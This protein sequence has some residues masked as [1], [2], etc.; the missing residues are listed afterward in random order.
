MKKFIRLVAILGFSLCSFAAS[1]EESI[2][3]ELKFTNKSEDR[4]LSLRLAQ[5]TGIQQLKGIN[6]SVPLWLPIDNPR[7]VSFAVEGA[8]TDWE[9]NFQVCQHAAGENAA[10]T[11]CSAVEALICHIHVSGV[12]SLPFYSSKNQHPELH[13][14]PELIA[15]KAHADFEIH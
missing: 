13:C 9:M 2:D 7:V 4:S 8:T 10:E 11:S 6:P 12:G 3:Y 15:N 5:H 14:S 1:S